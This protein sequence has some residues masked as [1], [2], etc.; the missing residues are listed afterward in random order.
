MH[1]QLARTFLTPL[2]SFQQTSG[3]VQVEIETERL[4]IRSYDENDFKNCVSLYSNNK[5]TKYFDRGMARNELEIRRLVEEKGIKY[6][7]QGKPFGLFSIFHKNSMTFMGQID[8]L[9]VNND[10][11]FELGFILDEKYQNKGFCTEASRAILYN[12][13]ESLNNLFRC[14]ELPITK[15]L[16]TAHPRNKASR[17]V[18][19]KI[20]MTI[21]KIQERFGQPRMWYSFILIND[22]Q[23]VISR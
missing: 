20:G 6:F 12:Y 9:P 19:E 5:I 22:N 17:K 10:G 1:P 4:C 21:E 16:A 8:L 15:V 23:K 11:V 7:T 13:T 2:V 14:K 18:L 3:S